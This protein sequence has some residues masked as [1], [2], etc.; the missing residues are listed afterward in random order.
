LPG[1]ETQKIK[2]NFSLGFQNSLGHQLNVK[3]LFAQDGLF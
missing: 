2:Q 1:F 3:D